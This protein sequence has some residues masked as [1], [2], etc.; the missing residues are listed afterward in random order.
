[1]RRTEADTI[2]FGVYVVAAVFCLPVRVTA[3]TLLSDH[4]G[5]VTRFKHGVRGKARIRS[6]DSR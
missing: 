5:V 2:P 3:E 1:M 4:G 6:F